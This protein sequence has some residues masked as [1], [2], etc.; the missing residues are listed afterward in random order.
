ME[1]MTIRRIEQNSE[2]RQT[3]V[4]TRSCHFR[5]SEINEK[6]KLEENRNNNSQ[7]KRAKG[8]DKDVGTTGD[9]FGPL[10]CPKHPTCEYTSAMRRC[11]FE[12]EEEEQCN[13]TL[14]RRC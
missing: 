1:E 4:S 2:R 7:M 14:K 3:T 9:Y 5:K 8:D 13:E 6:E 11:T 12:E 10:K